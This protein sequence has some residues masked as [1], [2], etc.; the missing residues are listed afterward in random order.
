MPP[1]FTFL[2]A[3]FLQEA[4]LSARN[5]ASN[6][7]K[8]KI[9]SVG[10]TSQSQEPLSVEDGKPGCP[11]IVKKVDQEYDHGKWSREIEWF[12]N[13]NKSQVGSLAMRKLLNDELPV[14]QKGSSP[15]SNEGEDL[16]NLPIYDGELA[17]LSYVN[18]QEPGDLSQ[19]NA[20]DF[21]D[22][23][24][25]DNIMKLDEE[26]DHDK[27]VQEKPKSLPRPSTK[28]QHSLAK[29]IND[30]GIEGRTCTYDW[31]D[32]CESERGEIFVR[33]KNLFYEGESC[34]Q[35][36]SPGVSKIKVSEPNE[37]EYGEE[38]LS[39]FNKRESAAHSDSRLLM[40]NLEVRDNNVQETAIKST[41]NLDNG[42]DKQLNIN[43]SIGQL[44]P[45]AVTADAPE[46]LGVGLDTQMAAEAMEALC[47]YEGTVS[48]DDNGRSSLT[49]PPSC[50]ASGK[51]RPITS[52]VLS[53]QYGR[54]RKLND[55]KS[56]LHTSSSANSYTKE[57]KQ[58]CQRD[59]R[60]RRSKRSKLNAEHNQTSISGENDSNFPSKSIKRRTSTGVFKT[61]QFEGLNSGTGSMKG[62]G[63][64]SVNQRHLQDGLCYF[65]PI[66]SRTRQS[67]VINQ[68]VKPGR[69]SRSFG[70]EYREV[71]SLKNRIS[72]NG[73]QVSKE[74]DLKSSIDCS[75]HSGMDENT[76]LCQL[77][78]SSSKF[79]YV[80][81]GIIV[82]GLEIPRRRRSLQ[83]LSCHNKGSEM[84]GSSKSSAWSEDAWK[85]IAKKRKLRT[86]ATRVAKSNMNGQTQSSSY[87][88]SIISSIDRKQRK[89]LES[90]LDKPNPGD[91]SL[92]PYV[93]KDAN[94]K[95]DGKKDA[96]FMLSAQSFE[97]TT[98]V[99]YNLTSS[100]LTNFKT[101]EKSAS[102]L[103]MGDKYYRKSG[104]KNTSRSIRV[105][106]YSG[107]RHKE[108]QS[109]SAAGPETTTSPK[110]SRKR[111]DM[112]DVRVLFSHHLDDDIIKH[113]KKVLSVFSSTLGS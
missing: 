68:F 25:E 23:F 79:S 32:N 112:T 55:V 111:R 72:C 102:P 63:M 24:L 38:Q 28:G 47:N 57:S 82:D 17:G 61:P 14:E 88:S 65:S 58:L 51:T 27:N 22:R 52:K 4:G 30:S 40:Q 31:Y 74:S 109:P 15:R 42:C 41:R 21:I 20:L 93:D 48:L 33:R 29:R 85:S 77:E 90:I 2:P 13:K 97:D 69:P 107:D 76:K 1:R 36:S 96:D 80:D 73:I 44:E 110:D 43:S 94:L 45:N 104:N 39:I 64:R 84:G 87:S 8:G 35:K 16:A 113:Q 18:S 86:E 6:Q 60:M 103:F 92:C 7:G 59:N 54:K 70:E 62:R 106:E 26:V 11:D 81:N 83:R 9:D 101:A 50:S 5:V 100:T 108:L 3:E 78:K 37:Y 99:S 91:T 71:V 34:R 53:R 67:L 46:M 66:A 75:D 10:N 98:S 105:K 12:M 95:T 56:N 19:A 89:L 49:E